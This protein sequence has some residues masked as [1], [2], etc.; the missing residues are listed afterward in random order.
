MSTKNPKGAVLTGVVAAIAASSCC[1]PPVLAAIAG[2][3]G[4][5]SSMSWMEPYRPYLIG[6]AIL[7]IGYAWYSHFKPKEADDCGCDIE[8]S[9]WYQSKTFLISMTLFAVLS[10][11]FPYY[12]GR[13][14]PDNAKNV[15]V[16]NKEDLV[17]VE[18][19]IDGMTCD[20][21]Q[22]HVDHAVNELDGIVSIETSYNKGNSIIAFDKT[23]TNQ[24]EIKKAVE[25]TG[26][27]AT[28]L[29]ER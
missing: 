5:S 15:V 7:A 17:T 19:T 21:C 4:A 26:Y 2:V 18:V 22:N 27:K 29:I 9:K 6:L 3:G 24:E 14:F 13:F 25:S 11:G 20:A 8:K 23:Q 10:I 28:K 12:S 1:I 16:E